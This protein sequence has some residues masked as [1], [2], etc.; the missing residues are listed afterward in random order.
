MTF[1]QPLFLVLGVMIAVPFIIHLFGERKYQ[2]LHFSSLKFLREIER[3]TL[4]KL[5]WRQWLILLAR[6]IWI[7]MIVFALAQP[8]LL[9]NRGVL[10]PGILIVDQSFSTKID[11]VYQQKIDILRSHYSRWEFL[12]YDERTQVDSF[13]AQLED[14]IR[15]KKLKETTILIFSDLQDNDQNKMIYSEID[16]LSSNVYTI[17]SVKENKNYGVSLLRRSWNENIFDEMQGLDMQLS[18]SDGKYDF[19]SLNI[20]LNG[21]QVGRADVNNEGMGSFYFSQ[22]ENE[23][24]LCVVSGQNDDYPQDNKRYMLIKDLSKI[25]LL[26]VYDPRENSYLKNAFEAIDQI[27]LSEITPE[28]LLTVDLENYDV[29]WFANAY[30]Q[31][32]RTLAGLKKYAQNKVLVLTVG[33]QPA[34]KDWKALSGNLTLN[35]EQKA[36]LS[37]INNLSPG[38]DKEL[39]LK[40]YYTTD[41]ER[42]T[43]LWELNS[44]DPL[45]MEVT[46]NIYMILSPF[47]FE[48]NEMGLSP[49]FTRLINEFLDY[50]MRVEPDIYHLGDAIKVEQAFSTVLTPRGEVFQVKDEFAETNI[51]GFYS[52]QTGGTTRRVAVNIPAE[53]CIQARIKPTGKKVLEWRSIDIQE[54]DRMIQGRDGQIIFYILALVLLFLEM[55]LML[56]GESSK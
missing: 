3:E 32:E 41:L 44:G 6:A 40:R 52:I 27:S 8:F 48:W 17:M 33:S 50:A 55:I 46:E 39:R 20:T 22:Q 30:A 12:Y 29:I 21:K 45:L 7:A 42:K 4:Q 31:N 38:K 11:P 9:G 37:V 26:Y 14:I 34:I 5:K 2:P 36:Y 15:S 35:P 23:D 47:Y 16:K 28:N 19:V 56:K 24:V 13:K 53:E 10:E 1:L 25:K 54:V 49:Y 18:S 51:A 43:A